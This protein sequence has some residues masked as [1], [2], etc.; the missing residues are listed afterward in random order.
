MLLTGPFGPN[1]IPAQG[2][3]YRLTQQFRNIELVSI[4]T[5]LRARDGPGGQA[6][7]APFDR[8][9]LEWTRVRQA[10]IEHEQ[11]APSELLP[12]LVRR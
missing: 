5:Y 6:A 8:R 10:R 2:R 4:G 12:L 11:L 3:A 1:Y 7:T 9:A